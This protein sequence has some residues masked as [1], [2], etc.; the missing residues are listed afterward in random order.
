MQNQYIQTAALYTITQDMPQSQNT[1]TVT[2]Q[3]VRVSDGYYYSFSNQ[4]WGAAQVTGNMSYVTGTFWKSA[5]MPTIDDTYLITINDTTIDSQNT[6]TLISITE[7]VIPVPVPP[8]PV[9]SG[10][11]ALI[12]LAKLYMPAKFVTQVSDQKILAFLNLVLAD[13]NAVSPMTGYTLDNMPTTWAPIVCFGAEVYSSL[14]LVANYTLQD[15]SYSDNGLSLNI[16]RTSKISPLYD[17]MLINYNLMKINLKKAEAVSTGAR[18][19]ATNYYFSVVGQFISQIFP[20]TVPN[21]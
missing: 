19:L 5:F 4:T 9:P 3:I 20:G 14:F 21:N 11:Q 17:K 6:Q 16:D 18:V 10:Q 15:F 7:W 8:Q 2:I 13:I 1:D 12:D